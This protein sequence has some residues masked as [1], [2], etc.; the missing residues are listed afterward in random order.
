MSQNNQVSIKAFGLNALHQ[1]LSSST[2]H[3]DQMHRSP[4]FLMPGRNKVASLKIEAVQSGIMTPSF[5]G[6]Y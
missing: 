2:V 4:R 6:F 1:S 3:D 5:D